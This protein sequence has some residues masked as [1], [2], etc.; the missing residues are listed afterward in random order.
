[1]S[2]RDS[3]VF[4]TRDVTDLVDDTEHGP[5]LRRSVSALGPDGCPVGCRQKG[6]SWSPTWVAGGPRTGWRPSSARI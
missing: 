2:L 5:Q 4:A 6:G 3:G 1:M